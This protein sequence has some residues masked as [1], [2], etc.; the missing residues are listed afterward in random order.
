MRGI[1]RVLYVSVKLKLDSI[2]APAFPRD[3]L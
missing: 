1:P 3:P 2:S